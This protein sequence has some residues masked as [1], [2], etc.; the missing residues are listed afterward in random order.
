MIC[1]KCNLDKPVE[2]Y[3]MREHGPRRVCKECL[4]KQKVLRTYGMSSEEYDELYN[5]PQCHI[6]KK[7]EVQIVYGKVKTLA[8]DH[9]HSEGSVRG[10]LCQACNVGLGAFKDDPS[11]L[12]NAIKY[13]KKGNP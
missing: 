3:Y 12:R 9:C 11:L 2:D 1:R 10:L 8:V 4:R 6:C 7:H 5:D 13:L